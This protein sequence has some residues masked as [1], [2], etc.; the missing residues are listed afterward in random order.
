MQYAPGFHYKIKI[1]KKKEKMLLTQRRSF[2]GIP[3]SHS[4]YAYQKK[5]TKKNGKKTE[6]NAF[7]VKREL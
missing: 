2:G 3:I 7:A 6:K 5:S 1:L 4:F